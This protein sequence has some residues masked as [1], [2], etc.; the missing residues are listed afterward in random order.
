MPDPISSKANTST[1]ARIPHVS[2]KTL[3]LREASQLPQHPIM[4]EEVT[5]GGQSSLAGNVPR[6]GKPITNTS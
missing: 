6:L 1:M 2:K 3:R 5:Q 4:Q